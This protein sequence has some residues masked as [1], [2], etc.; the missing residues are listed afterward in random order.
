MSPI[1]IFEVFHVFS[2]GRGWS[3]GVTDGHNRLLNQ[4]ISRP[5]TWQM[6]N[7]D[8]YI[9]E[10]RELQCNKK[11]RGNQKKRNCLVGGANCYFYPYCSR[12]L[13]LRSR[14]LRKPAGRTKD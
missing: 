1:D 3:C 6:S 8:M 14:G 12:D 5:T 4:G 11:T 13:F 10:Y 2:G 9:S 7:V